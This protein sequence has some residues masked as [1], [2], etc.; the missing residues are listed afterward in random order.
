MNKISDLDGENVDAKVYEYDEEEHTNEMYKK[1]LELALQQISSE[2]R[3]AIVLS[4]FHGMTYKIIAEMSDCT[5]N[6]IK[7]RVQ[8][9]IMEI[10]E[11]LEK[12]NA[13]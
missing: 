11:C 3:D 10:K 7:S 5:E 9:G 12:M 13:V 8:R 2:K 1:Q 6:A 4:R